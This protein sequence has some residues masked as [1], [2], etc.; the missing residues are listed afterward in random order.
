MRE[1]KKWMPSC[2]VFKLIAVKD[3]RDEIMKRWL[4][5]GKF[6]VCVISYE[7]VNICLNRL[8]RF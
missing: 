8:K 4:Q 1:F 6:D 7:G 3:E 2:R 5:P